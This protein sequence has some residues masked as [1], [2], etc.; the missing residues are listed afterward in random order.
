MKKLTKAVICVI[1]AMS[2][3][4][5]A[6]AASPQSIADSFTS[7]FDGIVRFFSILIG[8]ISD[9]FEGGYTRI[10][11]ENYTEQG[12]DMPG[13]DSGFVP[14]GLCF[15][16]ELNA[17]LISGYTDDGNS[18]IYV[19]NATTNEEKEIILKDFTAHAGVIAS[20][21]NS[22]W[23]SSGSYVYHISTED[24]ANA[25]S[26]A[27]LEFDSKIKL[28][29]KGSF[30]GCSNDMIWVGE[31]YTNSGGYEV[32]PDHA[33]GKNHSWACGYSVNDGSL[34]LEAVISVPDEVQGMTVLS[35]NTVIFST[36]YGRYNDSALQIYRPY[37]E[38]KQSTVNI[39][40]EDIPFHGCDKSDR[41]AKIEMPTLM[42]GIEIADGKLCVIY[43]SGAEKYSN[44][45]E[46]INCVQIIEIDEVL[47]KIR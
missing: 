41:I 34:K 23:V 5:S 44:A 29:V 19:V 30:M 17:Y 21:G 36:S 43:E 13:L 45:K 42:Q 11:I 37:T 14:Q 46:V 18:R 40:G 35:D 25:A 9:L 10:D 39:D 38:W 16:D 20:S 24:I 12:F 2:L 22:I 26:G 6:S 31:F 7:F 4:F 47:N 28:P 33:Y 32:D 1:L 3:T 8:D 27:E 15:S